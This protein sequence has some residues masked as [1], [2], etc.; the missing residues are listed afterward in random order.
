MAVTGVLVVLGT[1]VAR[2][3]TCAILFEA[4]GF[5]WMLRDA[6]IEYSITLGLGLVRR[7]Q[8]KR[9]LRGEH[10]AKP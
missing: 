1:P 3:G 5:W 6:G 8:A 9:E 4:Q 2:R 10:E 7:N